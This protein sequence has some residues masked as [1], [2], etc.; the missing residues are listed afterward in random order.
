VTTFQLL[1]SD[2]EPFSLKLNHEL[3]VASILLFG[4]GGSETLTL[5]SFA[6]Y[7]TGTVHALPPNKISLLA[8]PD[9]ALFGIKALSA[10]PLK[11]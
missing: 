4:P 5:F 7:L 3:F 2:L 11:T 1:S 6:D 10:R 8:L 9:N